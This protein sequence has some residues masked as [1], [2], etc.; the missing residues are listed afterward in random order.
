MFWGNDWFGCQNPFCM[1]MLQYIEPRHVVGNTESATA[2]DIIGYALDGDSPQTQS[3]VI[4]AD[5]S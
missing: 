2:M 1:I 4:K 5:G 3:I